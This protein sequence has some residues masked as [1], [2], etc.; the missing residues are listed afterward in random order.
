MRRYV[1]EGVPNESDE[2]GHGTHVCGSIAGNNASS[3]PSRRR[4]QLRR[5]LG[6]VDA[7][8]DEDEQNADGVAKDARLAFTDLAGSDGGVSSLY[9]PHF[10]N[11]AHSLKPRSLKIDPSRRPCRRLLL[12]HSHTSMSDCKDARRRAR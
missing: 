12:T 5:L 3:S 9:N 1:E 8:A 6:G 4:R 2:D 10:A 11:P 7:A